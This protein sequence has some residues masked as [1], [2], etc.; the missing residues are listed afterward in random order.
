MKKHMKNYFVNN[1]YSKNSCPKTIRGPVFSI[2]DN[3]LQSFTMNGF[4][5][6]KFDWYFSDTSGEVLNWSNDFYKD[7]K[8][9]VSKAVKEKGNIY[10]S[11]DRLLPDVF[12]KYPVS[13]KTVAVIGSATPLYEAY[14]DYFGGKPLTIEYRKIKHNIP[15]LLTYTFN[16]AVAKINNGGL[17]TDHAFCYSSIEHSGLGRYG[18]YI[19]PNGDLF[20]MRMIRKLVRQG[21]LLFLQI[22]VGRDLLLWNNTRIYGANRLLLLLEGWKLLSTFD[23][24]PELLNQS[25]NDPFDVIF[26]LQNSRPDNSQQQL[27][28]KNIIANFFALEGNR[29]GWHKKIKRLSSGFNFQKSNN[30]PR[31]NYVPPQKL[32]FNIMLKK[33]VNRLRLL[34]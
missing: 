33:M 10:Y 25:E 20:T 4:A 13:S 23:Y 15:H 28:T 3:L 1:K 29:S 17:R 21:G 26:V 24:S 5:R 19:D 31:I 11:T 7:L 16:E 32:L 12:K 18:D 9:T 14:T 2:P 34:L 22:P 27:F 6:I 8:K 30:N